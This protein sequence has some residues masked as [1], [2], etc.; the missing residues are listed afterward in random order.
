VTQKQKKVFINGVEYYKEESENR[1]TFSR[2]DQ[3]SNMRVVN[4]FS[5]GPDSRLHMESFKK[6]IAAFLCKEW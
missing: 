5:A 1:K 4:V 3:R 6:S 2:L